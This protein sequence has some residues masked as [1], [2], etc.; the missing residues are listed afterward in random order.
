MASSCAATGVGNE[1]RTP[2]VRAAANCPLSVI[3][4][5]LGSCQEM[6]ALT[7]FLSALGCAGI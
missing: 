3:G 1:D 7:V 6:T 2:C 5:G 4:L